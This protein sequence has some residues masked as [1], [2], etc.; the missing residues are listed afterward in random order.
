[1]FVSIVILVAIVG[2]FIALFLEVAELQ[3][4]APSFK[5]ALTEQTPIIK[6]QV[7]TFIGSH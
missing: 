1:M 5:N 7:I 3:S 2:C 6:E 4:E